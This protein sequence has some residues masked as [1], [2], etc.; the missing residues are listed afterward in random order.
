MTA[1][2]VKK[3]LARLGMSLKTEIEHALAG[4]S[5]RSIV[6]LL[7]EARLPVAQ[8][9]DGTGKVTNKVLSLLDMLTMLDQSTSLSQL[10]QD[11]TRKTDLPPLPPNTLL[12][13]L[14]E[15]PE[16]NSITVTG[17]VE[18]E[19]YV[20]VLDQG[21]ITR[22]FDIPLPHIVYRAVYDQEKS[23]LRNLSL[24]LCVE[25]PDKSEPS[26]TSETSSTATNSGEVYKWRP[27]VHSPLSR[28]PCSNVYGSFGGVSEGVCWPGLGSLP[29]TLHE[30]PEEA[31]R[32]FVRTEN[33]ADLYGRGLSHNAPYEDYGGF[34]KAIE[35]G[36]HIQEDYL[37]P[38]GTTV[39]DLHHQRHKKPGT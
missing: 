1:T 3:D 8:I 14:T 36:G 24:A 37:I 32:R 30:I 33:N 28:W 27:D 9:T 13:S 18:P 21:G 20:F 10:R 2:T 31:V 16:G 4:E 35:E 22:T 17:Y 5:H 15:T 25:P 6:L 7:R 12:T 38:T 23:S 39:E 34:L 26:D 11:A 19:T 29:M